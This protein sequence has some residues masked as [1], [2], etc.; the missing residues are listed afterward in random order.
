MY[1]KSEQSSI[2]PEN[3]ELPKET[4]LSAN[5]RWVIM[6]ELIPWS[7][8]EEEYAKNF[9]E[10]K[11]A[12][13][14]SFR[15]AL[16][17]LIIK[18]GA[19]LENLN[20]RQ[21]NLLLVVKKIYEQQLEMWS[22]KTQRVDQRI[23]SLTQPHIRP[24]VRGKAGKPTEFGAKLSVSCVDNYIFLSKLIRQLLSLFLSLFISVRTTEL[25]QR[26]YFN[27]SYIESHFFT[28]KLIIWEANYWHLTA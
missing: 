1:H 3:F 12:P 11:G 15:M 2:A 21:N 20:K 25:I 14:K 22:N 8:F 10:E 27:K 7:E 5:N 6:A 18:E 23:V 17:S 16:G 24:I 28:V 9:S 4:K 13:A 26:G 19:N